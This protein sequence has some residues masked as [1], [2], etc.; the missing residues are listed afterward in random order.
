MKRQGKTYLSDNNVAIS[1]ELSLQHALG[2]RNNDVIIV[3]ISAASIEQQIKNWRQHQQNENKH[4]HMIK[5]KR[6]G[7]GMTWRAA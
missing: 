3:A 7:V 6:D 1:G 2:N 4:R 5:H